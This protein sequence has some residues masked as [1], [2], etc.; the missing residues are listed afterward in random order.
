[1]FPRFTLFECKKK[2]FQQFWNCFQ[3]NIEAKKKQFRTIECK[4]QCDFIEIVFSKENKTYN[5]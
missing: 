3:K 4:N 1:M 5:R 2:N